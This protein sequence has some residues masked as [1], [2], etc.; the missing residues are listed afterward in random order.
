VVEEP[1]C[2]AALFLPQN[3]NTIAVTKYFL[4]A[5]IPSVTL[6]AYPVIGATRRSYKENHMKYLKML[7]LAAVSAM[8][9]MAVVGASAAS[10]TTLEV[11][12]V[13][14]TSAVEIVAS[15]EPGTSALLKDSAGTTTDTCTTSEVK[16]KT[17]VFTGAAVSGP[18]STLTFGNCTHTT[19]VLA[20]GSLSV[21]WISGTTNG[22]VNSIGAEVTVQST[23]FGVS[24]ICK[25]GT[26]TD[27]GTLTGVKTGKATMDINGKI[28]CGILGTA[29]WTGAYVVTSPEGLGVI[30]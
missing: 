9:L 23:A 19:T 1:P 3:Q 26:G 21:T 14:K 16:G 27:I 17:S 22:T 25:T 24:A 29:T 4:T 8:A 13:A 11:G 10:A 20:K 18:I 12:G 2:R 7:G 30:N 6:V 5:C 28:N 15:L